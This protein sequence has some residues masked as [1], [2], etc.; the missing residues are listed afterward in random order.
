M[1][2]AWA[3]LLVSSSYAA[4]LLYVPVLVRMQRACPAGA[5]SCRAAACHLACILLVWLLEL[6]M[7]CCCRVPGV[8]EAQPGE[9]AAAPRGAGSRVIFLPLLSIRIAPHAN[10]ALVPVN[11][12]E[13]QLDEQAAAQQRAAMQEDPRGGGRAVPDAGSE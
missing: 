7:A 11:R 9:Q 12:G 3:A 8:E 4:W 2:A 5:A 13:A 6:F 1:P 10:L